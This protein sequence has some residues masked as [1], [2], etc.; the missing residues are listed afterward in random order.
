M[1]ATATKGSRN[2]ECIPPGCLLRAR[3]AR[4]W[5]RRRR[6][7]ACSSATAAKQDGPLRGRHCSVL[8]ARREG[9][10]HQGRQLDFR[11]EQQDNPEF[12]IVSGFIGLLRHASRL[13][14]LHQLL[15]GIP[16]AP[17]EF[18][19]VRPRRLRVVRW[20]RVW[21][22]LHLYRCTGPSVKGAGPKMVLANLPCAPINTIDQVMR[23]PQ[24][25]ANDM[26][27]ERER[28][29]GTV[30]QMLG[31]PFNLSK[32]PANPGAADPPQCCRSG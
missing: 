14:A 27:I 20:A 30:V 25:L 29:D 22:P 3:R 23:D 1:D 26:V 2:Q 17:F 8:K 19:K 16:R 6:R 4:E 21:C 28:D 11:E 12:D 9:G 24:V 13:Q 5:R 10:G 31:V 32:T 15:S 7:G 18:G